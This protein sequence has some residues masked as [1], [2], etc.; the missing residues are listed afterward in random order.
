LHWAFVVQPTQVPVVASHAGFVPPHRAPLVVEQTPQ[1]P[2]GWQ[3]GVAPPHWASL[4]QPVQ[5]RVVRL[6]TGAAAPQSAFESQP[7][8]RPFAMLHEGVAPTQ[9]FMFVEE[10]WPQAPDGWQAGVAPPQSRSLAHGTQVCVT[11]SQT[12]SVPAHWAAEVQATH[13]PTVA[14]Q[15]ARPVPAHL[16]RF[17]TEHWPHEPFIWQAGALAGHCASLVHGTHVW[18]ALEQ[19]GI[20]P[21][22]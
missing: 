13:W 7:T 1:A 3:A 12:G 9:A 5:V 21:P 14:S 18:L 6:Q 22:H 17:V 20:V 15:A 16:V 8:H 10:H 19:T 2:L 4:V 11:R